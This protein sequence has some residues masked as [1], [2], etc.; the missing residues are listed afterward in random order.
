MSKQ[1]LNT[2]NWKVNEILN[3]EKK[4]QGLPE[5]KQTM[6]KQITERLQNLSDKN[7]EFLEQISSAAEDFSHNPRDIKRF[8]NVLRFERFIWYALL[9]QI[10]EEPCSFNQLRRWIFLSLKWPAFVRWLYWSSTIS[11]NKNVK[12]VNPIQER[13]QWL[14]ELGASCKE[15]N[16]W[17]KMTEERLKI[18]SKSIHWLKDEEL[19]KFFK[20]EGM[21]NNIKQRLSYS[22]GKGV[23]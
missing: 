15:L 9:E 18:S 7:Q 20:D 21:L 17:I 1:K 5:D 13:L 22:A 23:Y 12:R 3:E 14:E 2:S 11:S 4:L 6:V 8:V 10:G 19:F 16:E